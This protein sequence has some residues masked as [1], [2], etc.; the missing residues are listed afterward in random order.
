MKRSV[1]TGAWIAGGLVAAAML[2]P[3]VSYAAA[4]LTQIA[5]TNGKTIAQVSKARQLYVAPSD[6]SAAVTFEAGYASA[7]SSS[8][9]T[10]G[11]APAGNA[12]VITDLR[13]DVSAGDPALDT[14]YVSANTGCGAPAVIQLAPTAGNGEFQF[15]AGLA[16]P[17]G[18]GLSF[19]VVN[20]SGSVDGITLYAD[21]YTVPSSAVPAATRVVSR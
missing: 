13:Y 6:P 5:G 12:L 8:C 20:G 9:L 4:T 7:S 14:V 2:V 16:V 11:T 18:S 3:G 1:P 17:A 21:G 19:H 10:L 15:P